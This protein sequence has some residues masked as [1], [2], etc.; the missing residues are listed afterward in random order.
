[1]LPLLPTLDKLTTVIFSVKYGGLDFILNLTTQTIV[2]GR[3][4]VLTLGKLVYFL[5]GAHTSLSC[6]GCRSWFDSQ[7]ELMAGS[8]DRKKI[9]K[10][11]V[12]NATR[13]RKGFI[14]TQILSTNKLLNFLST[15]I[16]IGP[17]MIET[18]KSL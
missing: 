6:Q 17:K 12:F 16:L 8:R 1:M 18:L 10:V 13:D 7:S 11:L 15:H 2:A 4:Q 9:L 14:K 3:T 5:D